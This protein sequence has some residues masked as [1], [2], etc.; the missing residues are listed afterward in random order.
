M[1]KQR[2]KKQSIETNDIGTLSVEVN[3][4]VGENGVTQT[5]DMNDTRFINITE[6]ALRI[7]K[8][9]TEE[10]AYNIA[11]GLVEANGRIRG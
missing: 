2:A 8:I 10:I 11:K 3:D 5:Q 1:S 4:L 6:E 7:G 9:P